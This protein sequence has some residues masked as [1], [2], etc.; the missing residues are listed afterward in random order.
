MI[1]TIFYKVI[2][3]K[4]NYRIK[5]KIFNA[6]TGHIEYSYPEY[7]DDQGIIQSLFN[8]FKGWNSIDRINFKHI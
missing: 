8:H 2:N 1:I 3:D 6:L 4:K 5:I 7:H